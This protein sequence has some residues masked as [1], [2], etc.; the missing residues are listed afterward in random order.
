MAVFLCLGIGAAQA[1]DLSPNSNS[2]FDSNPSLASDPGLI[3]D[4][5]LDPDGDGYGDEQELKSGY[6]P[7]NPAKVK[8]DKSDMDKDGLSDY[9]ELKFKTDPLNADSD[10]DGYKDGAEIDFGFNPLSSSTVK[11]AQ[12]IEINLK[13]QKLVYFVGGQPW[14]EFSVS[15]GKA[16]MPTPKGNFK[17]FN[18]V[19]KAWSSTYKLWMP[20]WLGLDHGQFGIHELPVWPS[21]YRE[22]ESHLGT[23]VSHGC[24]R[25]GVGPAQYLYDRVSKGTEVVIK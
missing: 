4:L 17:I 12:K 22:G 24:I 13:I 2:N 20:Y 6:S 25:L 15:T 5:S 11:L 3:S 9:W 19:K 23:P 21:G 8:I 10:S 14:K 18:K 16:S 7:V 1:A